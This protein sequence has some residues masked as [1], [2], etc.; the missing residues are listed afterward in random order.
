MSDGL[1]L[2]VFTIEVDR[3]PV[4]ALQARKQ[5][6]IEPILADKH[7]RNQLS[8]LSSAGEP[9]CDK[10]SIFRIRIARAA[11]R[12]LYHDNN[13]ASLLTSDGQVAVLLVTLDDA[14]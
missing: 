4:L 2:S 10:F 5:S 6:E 9:L 13:A 1:S 11:E 12:Q 7:V 14:L 3:K 8:L